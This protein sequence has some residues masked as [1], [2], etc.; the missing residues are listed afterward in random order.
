[1]FPPWMLLVIDLTLELLPQVMLQLKRMQA[2]K[3]AKELMEVPLLMLASVT[4]FDAITG[5][6]FETGA[7][8]TAGGATGGG[9]MGSTFADG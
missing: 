4:G 5:I 6:G 2:I 1:M 7:T 8:S 9:S 3:L